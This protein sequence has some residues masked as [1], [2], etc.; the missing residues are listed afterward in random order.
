MQSFTV[1]QYLWSYLESLVYIEIY[2]CFWPGLCRVGQLLVY[3]N[4]TCVHER[5]CIILVTSYKYTLW[6]IYKVWQFRILYYIIMFWFILN[7]INTLQFCG[8]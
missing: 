3:L 5:E 4:V 2:K 6:I 8:F 1:E 7:N